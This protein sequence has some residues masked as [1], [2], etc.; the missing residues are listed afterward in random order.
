MTSRVQ[1]WIR[2]SFGQMV[3]RAANMTRTPPIAADHVEV[4]R[5][6]DRPQQDQ[7]MGDQ[8]DILESG[9][10]IPSTEP[11]P[12]TEMSASVD[13]LAEQ[14]LTLVDIVSAQEKDIKALKEQCRKLEEHNQ[15]VMVAFSA[16]YHV[17]SV[18]RVAKASEIASL[19][20]NISRIAEQED[21][22]QESIT[23]LQNLA[24]MVPGN[25]EDES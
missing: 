2:S 12:S 25:P 4:I 7:R 14:M 5:G 10:D 18:G 6:S 15:A 1:E 9:P 21:R 13:T 3:A 24:K 16:F 19:L 22:P 11:D 17:L 20:Q 23:F 8:T